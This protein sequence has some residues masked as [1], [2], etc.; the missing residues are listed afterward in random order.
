MRFAAL[1]CSDLRTASL[2]QLSAAI[3][4][5]FFLRAA[6]NCR[7]ATLLDL[8]STDWID[9]S[10]WLAVAPPGGCVLAAGEGAEMPR[11]RNERRRS[12][13]GRRRTD[14]EAEEASGSDATVIEYTTGSESGSESEPEH[15]SGRRRC[16]F[17]RRRGPRL[18]ECARDLLA[19]GFLVWVAK[20]IYARKHE[21][22]WF[23]PPSLTFPAA[24]PPPP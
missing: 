4:A 15:S 20:D 19:V 10:N 1:L 16:C 2:R 23:S 11:S 7:L 9:M 13:R 12:G 22:S 8:A 14:P 17:P 18:Y 21:V 6:V 3:S 5:R 24:P